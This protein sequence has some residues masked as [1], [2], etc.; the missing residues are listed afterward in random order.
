MPGCLAVGMT[1]AKALATVHG[2]PLVYVHHM[3]AHALTPLLTEPEP[4]SFPFLTLLVSGGHTMLVL[5]HGLDAFQI[6]ANTLDD[7]VGN[8]FDKFAREL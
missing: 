4:P 3:R 2:K 8:A 7:S 1:A 6:L 5:V